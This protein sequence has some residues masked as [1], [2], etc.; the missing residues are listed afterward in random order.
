M[1]FMP[2]IDEKS[3]LEILIETLRA[4]MIR[5]GIKEGLDSEKTIEISQRLDIYISKYHFLRN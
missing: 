4:E 5:I 3:K 2:M 1:I